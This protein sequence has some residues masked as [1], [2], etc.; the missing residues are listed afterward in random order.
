M[1]VNIVNSMR[2][3]GTETGFR[4]SRGDHDQHRLVTSVDGG[5]VVGALFNQ[6]VQPADDQQAH[7]TAGQSER[8]RV[9]AEAGGV[10]MTRTGRTGGSW[11]RWRTQ[12]PSHIFTY[13]YVTIYITYTYIHILYT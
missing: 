3:G 10:C 8:A 6:T 1:V 5:G 13:I 9:R 11:I 2:R 7:P 4:I 12:K